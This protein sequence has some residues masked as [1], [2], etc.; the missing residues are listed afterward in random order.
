MDFRLQTVSVT[1]VV[2][3]VVKTLEPLAAN[4]SIEIKVDVATAGDI[5]AD[6]GKL[7]QML[8]NLGSNAIKF[9]RDGGRVTIAAR[10][11]LNSVEFS[12]T[13]TGIGI[14]EA[15]LPLIF[16]EFHQLDAGPGRRQDGTG[17]GLALTKRFALLHGGD[18]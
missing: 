13:D 8:L 15:D 18:V 3:Q 1:E 7:K 6:A 12:V 9:T 14:A 10:R 17:L 4:K 16:K 11:S 5:T 2:A